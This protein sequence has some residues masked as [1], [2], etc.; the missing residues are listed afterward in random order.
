MATWQLT[1]IVILKKKT[2]A[3]I[4]PHPTKARY[5]FFLGQYASQNNNVL[6]K[7]KGEPKICAQH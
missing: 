5:K 4:M 2:Y 3:L 7:L 1:N 6:S